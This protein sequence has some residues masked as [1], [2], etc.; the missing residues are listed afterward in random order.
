[1]I[2][3]FTLEELKML[4]RKTRYNSRNQYFNADFTMLTLEE[5]IEMLLNW[6]EHFPRKDIG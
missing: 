2:N 1:L 4:R 3:D 5:T 6:N